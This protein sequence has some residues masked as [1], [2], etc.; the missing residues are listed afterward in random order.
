[1][2]LQCPSASF[3]KSCQ[4]QARF[5][6]G[7]VPD[8]LTKPRSLVCESKVALL[9]HLFKNYKPLKLVETMLQDMIYRIS[10]SDI[11]T[12]DKWISG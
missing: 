8:S 9:Q 12:M 3:C 7:K 1:M 11:Y 10:F 5:S 2:R 6:E 4:L